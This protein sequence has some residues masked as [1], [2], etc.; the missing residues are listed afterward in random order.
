MKRRLSDRVPALRFVTRLSAYTSA[1]KPGGRRMPPSSA[2]GAG[3]AGFAASAARPGS[4]TTSSN[5]TTAAERGGFLMVAGKLGEKD[6]NAKR[7]V[8]ISCDAIWP[9]VVPARRRDDREFR[10]GVRGGD[11]G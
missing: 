3:S 8:V 10:A 1:R 2:S 9:A 4:V 5:R 11:A 7:H 6:V